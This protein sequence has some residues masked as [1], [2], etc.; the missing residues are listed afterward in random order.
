MAERRT[1]GFEAPR[2]ARACRGRNCRRRLRAWRDMNTISLLAGLLVGAALGALIG[3][4]YARSHAAGQRLE[5]VCG[6]SLAG[7]VF[8]LRQKTAYEMATGR[9]EAANARA[10]GELD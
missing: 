10:A 5:M 6:G 7:E 2:S 4:L 9:L 3:Y 1:C 8:F